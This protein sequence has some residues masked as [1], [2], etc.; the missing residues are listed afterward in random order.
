LAWI[1]ANPRLD[2]IHEGLS[3]QDVDLTVHQFMVRIDRVGTREVNNHM[4][5]EIKTFSAP[6]SFAQEDTHLITHQLLHTGGRYKRVKD[7]RG[8]W[9][10]AKSWGYHR[11][12]FDKTNPED[13]TQIWWDS[14]P[15]DSAAL[16][17]LLTFRR[18]PDT[19]HPRSERRHHV[20]QMDGRL[21]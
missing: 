8:R 6:A 19:M 15:V 3:I 12:T 1:R 2:S 11:L 9:R 17:E 7:A 4:L 20:A 16:E 18:D 13:S 21:L 10:R 5:V 14:R